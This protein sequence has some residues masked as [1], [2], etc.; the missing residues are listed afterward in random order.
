MV[1]LSVGMRK[2][3][4]GWFF[5]MT[6]E[7]LQAAGHEDVRQVRHHPSLRTLIKGA[8][9]R[10]GGLK[11]GKLIRL[12]RFHYKGHT[13]AVK[14][15]SGPAL[16]LPLFTASGIAKVTYTYRDP[17]DVI[18]SALEHGAAARKAGMAFNLT[19]LKSLEDSIALAKK[20]IVKWEQWK[21]YP[22]VLMVRYE[23][24]VADTIGELHR[25]VTFL[26]IDV[27]D[28]AIQDIARRY[29]KQVY[30]QTTDNPIL[31][32]LHLNKGIPGRFR[33]EMTPEARALCE[34]QLGPQLRQMGYA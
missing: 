24:L 33:E 4:S 27:R 7:L 19:E 8:N 16:S 13:F 3:G 29:D 9:C 18:L 6:N 2:S 17:R 21:Q 10:V 11:L 30:A 1:V 32:N 28:E 12:A 31:N 5:N 22:H 25:L 14:S 23:E 34:E 15:H 26:G 20:E